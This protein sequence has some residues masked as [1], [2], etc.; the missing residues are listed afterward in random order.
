MERIMRA[1]G[2]VRTE[3]ARHV[4][5]K[6]LRRDVRG[7]G[8]GAEGGRVLGSERE[9]GEEKDGADHGGVKAMEAWRRPFGQV[10]RLA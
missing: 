9:G 10:R 1:L 4:Q 7:K 5:R 8:P 2:A 3:S 6:L